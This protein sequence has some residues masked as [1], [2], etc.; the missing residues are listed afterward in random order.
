MYDINKNVFLMTTG[1]QFQSELGV[2]FRKVAVKSLSKIRNDILYGGESNKELAHKVKGIA[3]SCGA[4][5]VARVCF[6]LEHYDG[7]ISKVSGQRILSDVSNVMIL[8]CD[9]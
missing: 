7:V 9:A 6:K 1:S 2:H 8:L 3:L 5:E 4:M